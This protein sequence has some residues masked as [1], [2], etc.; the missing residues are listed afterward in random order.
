M[1]KG[2]IFVLTSTLLLTALTSCGIFKRSRYVNMSPEELSSL[3]DE[4]LLE[5]VVARIE[6]KMDKYGELSLGFEALSQPEKLVFAID[7]YTLELDNGGLCQFFVNSSRIAA[8]Y[9]SEYLGTLGATDH[10]ALYDA[11][12]LNNGIDLNDLS[13]FNI[14]DASEYLRLYESYPFEEY[15]GAFYQLPHLNTYLVKY[16]RAHVCEL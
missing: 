3:S 14:D 13:S 16:V 1:K 4:K 2:L 8:P 9:V 10:K 11:F 12:V 6:K 7:Y 5:A 15:D